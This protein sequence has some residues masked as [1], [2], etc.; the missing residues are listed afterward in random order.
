MKLRLTH[1]AKQLSVLGYTAAVLIAFADLFHAIVIENHY[2]RIM[3]LTEIKDL[4]LMAQNLV[5]ALLLAISVV[6]MA[7]P[8]GSSLYN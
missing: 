6:V 5:H 3:M 4:P 2:D 7:V 1:L 8:E